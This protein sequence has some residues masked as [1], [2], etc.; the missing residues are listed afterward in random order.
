MIK[1]VIFDIDG[2]LLNTAINVKMG[3]DQAMMRFGMSTIPINKVKEFMG[4]GAEELI[5][6]CLIYNGDTELRRFGAAID[7]Y[8][9]FFDSHYNDNVT[10]YVGIYDSARDLKEM[11]I[12]L[13]VLSN[14]AQKAAHGNV[15][16]YFGLDL[17]DIIEGNKE[18]FAL[19]PAPDEALKIAKELGVHPAECLMLGD[20]EADIL[21]AK[22]AGM[23]SVA[24]LWGYRSRE[25]LAAC[26]PDYMLESHEGLV[27]LV[28]S[29]S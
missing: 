1:A 24:A 15:Q 20:S 19:K 18:G 6:A 8:K 25:E 16:R 9:S 3:C 17:F 11:G 2:T 12:K 23:V 10:S 7:C 5:K 26:E 14:K 27:E 4:H 21:T 22:N 28:K 29:I 13:A